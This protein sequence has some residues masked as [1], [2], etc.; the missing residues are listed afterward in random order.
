MNGKKAQTKPARSARPKKGKAASVSVLDGSREWSGTVGNR[1]RPGSREAA[2]KARHTAQDKFLDAYIRDA[3]VTAAALAA[4]VGRRT[5]YDWLERDTRYAARFGQA[6]EAATDALEREARRRAIDGV[7]EPVFYQGDEC[8]RVKKYSDTL[9]IF[10]LKGK[11]PEQFKE[12]FEHTGKGGGPIQTM[13]LSRLSLADLAK[14]ET[15]LKKLTPGASEEP[16]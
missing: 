3:T 9:L 4:K 10:L 1:P 15:V 5:H 6:E 2:D 12:R 14:L 13:D 7:E 16:S 11:R 8:G